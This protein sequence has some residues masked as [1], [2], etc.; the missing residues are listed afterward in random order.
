MVGT[1]TA[2]ATAPPSGDDVDLI[3]GGV[4]PGGAGVDLASGMAA[5]LQG[6][7][8]GDMQG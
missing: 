8:G 2:A 4:D 7:L 6:Q 5:A 1:T 3:V